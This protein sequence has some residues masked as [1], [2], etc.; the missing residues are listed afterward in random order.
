MNLAA[1]RLPDRARSRA[2]LL[3]A[4]T[5]MAEDVLVEADDALRGRAAEREAAKAF[6][7]EFT[8]E[9]TAEESQVILDKR[10]AEWAHELY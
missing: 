9:L 1:A 2:D 5:E 10:E 6:I 7:L 3:L 8:G 4:L